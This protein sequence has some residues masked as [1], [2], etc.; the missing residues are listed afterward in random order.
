MH[1]ISKCNFNGPSRPYDTTVTAR[2]N[3]AVVKL[4]GKLNIYISLDDDGIKKVSV[5][6]DGRRIA[7]KI[8]FRKT[9]PN[10]LRRSLPSPLNKTLRPFAGKTF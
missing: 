5:Q 10:P 9:R 1:A 7:E 2:R 8:C 4:L 6:I 3:R